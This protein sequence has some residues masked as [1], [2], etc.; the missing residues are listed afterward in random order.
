MPG[1]GGAAQNRRAFG[2]ADLGLLHPEQAGVLDDHDQS[3]R[4]DTEPGRALTEVET[5]LLDQLVLD[6][7]DRSPREKTLSGYLTKIP[8]SQG[9]AAI[10]L[11][12]A[13]HHRA[14]PSC[15]VASPASP[16][17]NWA[18]RSVRNLW[19]IES[20]TERLRCSLALIRRNVSAAAE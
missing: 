8:K 2:E 12:R 7:D 13:I 10:S 6:K 3:V 19:V 1:R 9:L 20:F 14:T 17:P 4:R 11:A 16:T 5:G 15:G 18:P